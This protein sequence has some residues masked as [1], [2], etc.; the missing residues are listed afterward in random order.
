[1][2]PLTMGL[3]YGGGSMLSGLGGMLGSSTQANA[4]GSA[5]QMG[6]L[7]SIMAAQAAEQ[8]FQRAQ[9]ALS[10]YS[11][12]GT[13]SLDLLQSYLTGNAAQ[14]AGV[15]GGGPSLISTFQ[16]TQAQLEQ[17]PGYQWAQSQ[18][19][20]AM[21]NSGAAKGLGTSGNLVQQ[22][23]QTATGLASQTFQQQLQN[24][25][26]QNQQAYNMLYGP[27]QLGANAAQ[28]IASAATGS[29]ANIGNALTGAGTA[30]GQGIM[31][32]GTY[33]GAGTNA[34]FGAAGSAMQTPY[35]YANFGTNSNTSAGTAGY[36]G[37]PAWLGNVLGGLGYSNMNYGPQQ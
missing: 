7:G 34:L 26:T 8:G 31:N 29:A 23:G 14:Q 37:I 1:M 24:Y 30:L 32:A 33:T 12:A 10:P 15:G 28:G 21:A 3:M 25:L 17:T 35:A 27:S 11:T 19:L 20:G 6:W 22:L 9:G 16:P 2:D 18:A 4:A 36:S 5:G 13:K